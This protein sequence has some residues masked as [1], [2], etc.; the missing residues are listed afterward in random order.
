MSFASEPYG[1]F[2]DDLV[3]ARVPFADA[4]AAYELVDRHPDET[5]GVLLEYPTDPAA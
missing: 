1:I 3:S 2:V 5:L 4:P